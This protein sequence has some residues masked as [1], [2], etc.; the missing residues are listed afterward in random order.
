VRGGRATGE[1]AAE[2]PRSEPGA[3]AASIAVAMPGLVEVRAGVPDVDTE[4]LAAS[5]GLAVEVP[6][7]MLD[8]GLSAERLAELRQRW[9]SAG[10]VCV[11]IDADPAPVEEELS[12]LTN[13]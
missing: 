2:P 1:R 5:L 13:L 7:G 10:G 3:G 12:L 9:P 8:R 11:A 6:V 4:A